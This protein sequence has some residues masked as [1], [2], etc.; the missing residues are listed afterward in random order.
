MGFK[1]WLKY[2]W[3]NFYI[4]KEIKV[5]FYFF[6]E[7]GIRI[8]TTLVSLDIE[9][10]EKMGLFQSGW[11]PYFKVERELKDKFTKQ[12]DKECLNRLRKIRK[13]KKVEF[14][15]GVLI[16]GKF[17]CKCTW[18]IDVKFKLATYKEFKKLKNNIIKC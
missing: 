12:L 7:S 17:I 5:S 9:N 10:Y 4:I 8:L 16:P 2:Q 6:T 15:E 14:E 18:D 3:S 13:Q 11:E 1:D